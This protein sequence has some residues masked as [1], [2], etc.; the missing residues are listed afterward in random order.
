MISGFLIAQDNAVWGRREAGF[1]P[2][3]RSPAEKGAGVAL[4]E[5]GF[6]L[7]IRAFW[8]E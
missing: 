8:I 2:G 1:F 4:A 6:F 5:T 7:K 3:S